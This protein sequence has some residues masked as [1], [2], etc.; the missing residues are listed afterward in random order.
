VS[1]LFEQ[2]SKTPLFEAI[3]ERKHPNGFLSFFLWQER[4][5]ALFPDR[6]ICREKSS[7]DEDDIGSLIYPIFRPA[8]HHSDNS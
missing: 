6:I 2:A 4:W 3:L 7:S 8:N 1:G 5:I